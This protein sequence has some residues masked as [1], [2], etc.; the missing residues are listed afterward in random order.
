MQSNRNYF[1]F[2]FAAFSFMSACKPASISEQKTLD[3]FA[4]QG[5]VSVNSCSGTQGVRPALAERIIINKTSCAQI[6]ASSAEKKYCDDVKAYLTAVPVE[7]QDAFIAMGGSINVRPDSSALCTDIMSNES[8]PQFAPAAERQ[9]IDSCF[10]FTQGK[11]GTK[12]AGKSVLAIVHSMN[13]EN[14]RHN[15]VRLFGF[16]YAQF[17]PRLNESVDNSGKKTFAFDAKLPIGSSFETYKSDLARNFFAD[18]LKQEKAGGKVKVSNLAPLIGQSGA[19]QVIANLNAGKVDVFEGLTFAYSAQ[20][21]V[22]ATSRQLR[23][24]RVKDFIFA[25]AFDSLVCSDKTRSVANRDFKKTSDFFASLLPV[26]KERSRMLASSQAAAPNLASVATKSAKSSGGTKLSLAGEEQYLLQ[27]LMAAFQNAGA[28]GGL[29]GAT[30]ASGLQGLF[31]AMDPTKSGAGLDS[32]LSGD[33]GGLF[34]SC[35]NCNCS[36][37]NCSGC[38]G[39]SCQSCANGS[40]GSC[41][42]CSGAYM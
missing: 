11:A 25:E 39:G 19:E 18:V 34:S 13:S 3:N 14:I 16:L 31:S 29:G 12:D 15:G 8:S 6:S 24:Q 1:A 17:V 36:S 38:S 37:G 23:L 41:A 21:N 20:E 30:G 26:I 22:S 5:L 27:M 28:A 33:G 40:C 9:K 2:A 35:P 7:V 4:A 32:L 42:G 10:M